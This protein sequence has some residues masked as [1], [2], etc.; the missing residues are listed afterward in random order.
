VV[1]AIPV[2]VVNVKLAAMD[3]DETTVLA[4]LLLVECV[5]V[6]VLDNITFVNCLASVSA[7][8]GIVLVS[9]F[10]LGMTTD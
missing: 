3:W 2:N 4:G 10:N 7:R 8:E 9:E 1:P 5:W 6:L